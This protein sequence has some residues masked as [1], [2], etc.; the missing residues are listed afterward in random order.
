MHEDGVDVFVGSATG[1]GIVGVALTADMSKADVEVKIL[2]DRTEPVIVT[3]PHRA[4]T[5][6][7]LTPASVRRG[8]RLEHWAHAR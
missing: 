1:A 5:P 2:L 3:H 6:A 8:A 7:S 4:A